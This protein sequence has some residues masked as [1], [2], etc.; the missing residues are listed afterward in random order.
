MKKTSFNFIISIL[1]DKGRVTQ[2]PL[3]SSNDF[4]NLTQA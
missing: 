3:T 2:L 1:I 4:W